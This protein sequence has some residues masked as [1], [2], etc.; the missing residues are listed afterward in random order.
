MNDLSAVSPL[1][2][3][4]SIAGPD[5]APRV[6]LD[7]AYQT[8]GSFAAMINQGLDQVNAAVLDAQAGAQQLAAGDLSDLHHVMLRIEES[9]LQF[10]LM[11][12]IRNRLLESYQEV[13]R[14]QV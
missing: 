5:L 1:V 12:Q 14:M 13:L 10:Q 9:R 11:M 6:G 2:Q 4:V 8:K 3:T 7:P